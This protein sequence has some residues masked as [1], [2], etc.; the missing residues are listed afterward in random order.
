AAKLKP[1][2]AAKIASKKAAKPHLVV[3]RKGPDPA[4]RPL[5]VLPPEARARAIER[6]LPAI[7]KNHARPVATRPTGDAVKV[8]GA[9]RVTEKD[10][11]ELEGRLLE[12]RRRILK[13]MGH[14]EN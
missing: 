9:Q 7:S 13:E 4:V 10:T 3:A 5:G 8:Q 11:K 1:V 14:L 12:A 2:I 6:V